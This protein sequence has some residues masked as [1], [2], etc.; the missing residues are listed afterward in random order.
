MKK[1]KK[2]GLTLNRKVIS[3]LKLKRLTG[4]NGSYQSCNGANDPADMNKPT[5]CHCF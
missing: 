1:R 4:G 5:I 3:N 2:V